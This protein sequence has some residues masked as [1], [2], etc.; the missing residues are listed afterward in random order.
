[1]ECDL[2]SLAGNSSVDKSQEDSKMS[3]IM[4][5]HEQKLCDF[6]HTERHMTT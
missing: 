1:M 5:F 6:P 4:H 3:G 2:S